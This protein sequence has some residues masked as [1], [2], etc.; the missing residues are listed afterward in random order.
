MLFRSMAGA[1][2]GAHLG[3]GAIPLDLAKKVNDRGTWGFTEL[4]ELADKCYELICKSRQI[5]PK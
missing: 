5:G 2:S 3:L 1:I 4:V